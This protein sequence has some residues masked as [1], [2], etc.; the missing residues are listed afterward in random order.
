MLCKLH[1]SPESQSFVYLQRVVLLRHEGLT[2]PGD[3]LTSERLS[4]RSSQLNACS[5]AQRDAPTITIGFLRDDGKKENGI[6]FREIDS[7]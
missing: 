4:K 2:G 6:S 5:R 1:F 3:M 7:R